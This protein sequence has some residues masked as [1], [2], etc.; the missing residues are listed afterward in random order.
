MGQYL[1][2]GLATEIIVEKRWN[3][4]EKILEKMKKKMDLN[5]Y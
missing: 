1:D 3:S 2:C 4:T 5:S